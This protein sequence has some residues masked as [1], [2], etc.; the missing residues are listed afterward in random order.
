M[1]DITVIDISRHQG[2]IDFNVM[3]A[4]GAV[5]VAM[6]ATI[7]NYYI[8]PNF[9][10]NWDKAGAAGLFRTAYHVVK[11][12]KTVASQMQHFSDAVGDRH[13][14][15]GI[16]G[17]VLDCE[18]DDGMDKRTIT[19]NIW[20]CATKFSDHCGL[21][22]FI[23][24]RMSWFNTFTYPGEWDNWPLWV[25]RYTSAPEPWSDDDPDYLKP[26]P[27]EWDDW[28]MWQYSAD[29]NGQGAFYGASSPDIDINHAKD[30]IFAGETPPTPPDELPK[31]LSAKIIAVEEENGFYKAELIISKDCT[32]GV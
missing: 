9:Y 6:R 25:A 2:E 16:G 14:D 23:Y 30:W 5:G 31:H 19:D 17:W 24:T 22:V 20:G 12:S 4:A 32:P 10:I 1:S 29:G 11:P 27:D 8:D 13:P 15:F 26:R 3:K 21:D 28:A 18:L 7:G